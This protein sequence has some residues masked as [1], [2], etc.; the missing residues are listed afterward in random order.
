MQVERHMVD[1]GGNVIDLLQWN[2]NVVSQVAGRVLDAMAQ[3]DG[4]DP[5]RACQSPAI[6]GHWIH[7]I[8]MHYTRTSALHLVAHF[9]QYRYGTQSAHDAADSERVRD[10]LPETKALGDFEIGHGTRPVAT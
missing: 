9:E 3:T 1:A 4:F 6:H 5:G 2:S 10:G 8:Q 7:V